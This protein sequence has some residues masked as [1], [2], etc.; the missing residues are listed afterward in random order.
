M[1]HTQLDNPGAPV[2]QRARL[3]EVTSDGRGVGAPRHDVSLRWPSAGFVSTAEDLTRL[4]GFAAGDLVG[5]ATRAQFLEEQRTAAGERTGYALGWEVHDT[6]FGMGYGHIGN[7]VGGTALV[8]VI[9]A[10][11]AVLALATNIG[12]V[13]AAS[14]PEIR[15]PDPHELLLPFL[16]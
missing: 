16:G 3:Y 1:S 10:R 13:T 9:P 6:P 11:R 12:Y 4:A 8:L 14:P 2:P 5:P 15:G 7:A